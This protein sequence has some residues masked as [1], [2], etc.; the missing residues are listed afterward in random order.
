[1]IV[2][3]TATGGRPEAFALCQKYVK[4]QTVSPVWI[5]V[6]DAEEPT[7]THDVSDIILRPRPRWPHVSEPNTQHR[8]ILEALDFMASFSNP[9]QPDDAIVFCEDDDFFTPDYIEKQ[10]ARLKDYPLVGESPTRY[11]HLRHR[12][13]RVFD[14]NPWASLAQTAMRAEMIPA[15]RDACEC[16]SMIDMHLWRLHGSKGK[17][18]ED[19]SVLG[20]KG[21]PGR[22]G[23][24]A[25]HTNP[26]DGRWQGDCPNLSRLRQWIGDADAEAYLKFIVPP[27]PVPVQY[28][29]YSREN[30][31]YGFKTFTSDGQTRYRCPECPY[32]SYDP[33]MTEKHFT[34]SHREQEDGMMNSTLFDHEGKKI[35][36]RIVVPK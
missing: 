7:A 16:R 25:V 4:R 33:N 35:T 24:T 27:E 12:A 1:M 17:L 29:D 10:V 28:Q 32:D 13:F 31:E 20:M 21:M 5:V 30:E 11:Y 9:L 15:L 2:A 22:A 18:Y 23:V 34:E 3:L 14:P 8:N 6:D 26:I 36:R 19:Y